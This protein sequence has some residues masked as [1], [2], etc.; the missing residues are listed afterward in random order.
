MPVLAINIIT[1]R[2]GNAAI[3]GQLL[4]WSDSEGSSGAP[5]VINTVEISWDAT[6]QLRHSLSVADCVTVRIIMTTSIVLSGLLLFS[7]G[8]LCK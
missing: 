3:P 5:R 8:I 1:K 6:F 2:S 4:L 7:K